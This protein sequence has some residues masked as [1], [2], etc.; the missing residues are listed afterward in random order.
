MLSFTL[1]SDKTTG[2]L[3]NSSDIRCRE[4]DFHRTS[5]N[6]NRLPVQEQDE[7]QSRNVFVREEVIIVVD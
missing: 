3:S 7:T 4:R 2:N 5:K 1:A 6:I